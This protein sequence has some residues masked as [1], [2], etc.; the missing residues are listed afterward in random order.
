MAKKKDNIRFLITHNNPKSPAAEAFRTLRTNLYY[1]SLDTTLRKILV[2]SAGPVE[3]KST[4]IANLAVTVA[5][6][7]QRVLIIDADL[8]KPVQHKIF[9]IDNTK[10][11]TNIIVENLDPKGIIQKTPIEGLDVLTS[12]PIPP[13]PSELVGSKRMEDF[14]NK[15]ED[16]EMILIDSPP[17]VAVTDAM[18]ISSKVDGVLIVINSKKVKI[19]IAKH[20]KEHLLKAKAKIIGVVLNNVEY[21][22]DDYQYYY[23][24]GDKK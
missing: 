6:A 14:L 7:G 3:G 11:L 13:N 24:Y 15:L 8:R 5:Q 22:G 2:T 1:S 18:L 16:Y 21:S 19:D 4:I 9:E 10:G 23:Y 20:I 17:A 12:G